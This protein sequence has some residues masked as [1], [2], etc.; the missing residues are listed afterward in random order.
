MALCALVARVSLTL[1]SAP[2]T[3]LMEIGRQISNF[4]L[5]K[6]PLT[7]F[8]AAKGRE[9]NESPRDRARVTHHSAQGAFDHRFVEVHVRHNTLSPGAFLQR[10]TCGGRAYGRPYVPPSRAEQHAGAR[11]AQPR[12][13]GASGMDKITTPGATES[14]TLVRMCMIHEVYSMVCI[15]LSR[16]STS[17]QNL[18]TLVRDTFVLTCGPVGSLS[19]SLKPPLRA[20]VRPGV[21][22]AWFGGKLWRV[23][24]ARVQGDFPADVRQ[25]GSVASR[26]EHHATCFILQVYDVQRDFAWTI[27]LILARGKLRFS[28]LEGGTATVSIES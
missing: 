9:R 27:V 7:G 12:L 3:R 11:T 15:L 17:K 28:I 20:A 4:E 5:K 26:C 8:G 24:G 25:H 1:L 16:L 10:R 22:R 14:T 21:E 2:L 23:G 13:R 18:S 6:W 19:L